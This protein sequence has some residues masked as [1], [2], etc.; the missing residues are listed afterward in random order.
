MLESGTGSRHE[1]EDAVARHRAEHESDQPT[2]TSD[3]AESDESTVESD[4]DDTPDTEDDPQVDEPERTEA[5]VEFW[6]ELAV[7]PIEIALPSGVGYTLRAYR[8]PDEVTAVP[9]AEPEPAEDQAPAGDEKPAGAAATVAAEEG[10]GTGRGVTAKATPASDDEDDEPAGKRGRRKGRKARKSAAAATDDAE[11]EATEGKA[12]EDGDTEDEASDGKSTTRSPA[13][14]EAAEDEDDTAEDDADE[15]AESDEDDEPDED[16]EED[17]EPAG[18]DEVPV[19]LSQRGKL[20]LFHTPAALVEFVRSDEPH[21]LRGIEQAEALAERL[22]AS[23][24]APDDDDHYEL[25]LLVKNLRGGHDTWE[26]AL[27][28]S[29]GELARDL[30][31]ALDLQSVQ[32]SLSPGSPLDD[33]DDAMR[34]R[35]NGGLGAFRARRRMRKIGAQQAALAWRTIIGKISAAVDWRD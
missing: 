8:S 3:E 30:A 2:S 24:I 10:S 21:S 17:E 35:M 16:D 32:T 23:H 11:D 31:Y 12:T 33:L 28:V 15:D 22:E 29:A 18:P 14:D 25:D 34:G 9:G 13:E 6:S 4:A 5:V 20:L 26:P 7:D 1:T 19:F 27:V